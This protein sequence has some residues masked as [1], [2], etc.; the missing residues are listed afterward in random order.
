MET[1]KA[2]GFTFK[3]FE[4]VEKYAQENGF[5]ISRTQTIKHKG[6]KIN[7]IELCQA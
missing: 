5:A 1:Y 6:K 3:T 2:N 7:L 4:E